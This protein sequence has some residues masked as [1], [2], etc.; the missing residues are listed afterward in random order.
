[1]LSIVPGYTRFARDQSAG[2]EVTPR[3]TAATRNLPTTAP[4]RSASTPA[5]ASQAAPA[6]GTSAGRG[7]TGRT[8]STGRAPAGAAAPRQD[9]GTGARPAAPLAPQAPSRQAPD[10]SGVS[11]VLRA[12]GFVASSEALQAVHTPEGYQV[13]A[14]AEGHILIRHVAIGEPVLGISP[15][16]RTEQML[17][18]Y[19]QALRAAGFHVT[20]HARGSLIVGPETARQPTPGRAPAG[21]A[22]GM[23]AP[24]SPA[25]VPDDAYRTPDHVAAGNARPRQPA[26]RPARE[27]TGE[28]E[29]GAPA[30]STRAEPQPPGPDGAPAPPPAGGGEQ[31]AHRSGETSQGITD[32]RAT[33]VGQ[34]PGRGDA[35]PQNTGGSPKQQHRSAGTGRPTGAAFGSGDLDRGSRLLAGTPGPDRIRPQ[36]PQEHDEQTSEHPAQG[37]AQ[38][39]AQ[40]T[41]KAPCPQCGKPHIRATGETYPCLSCE[42][43]A[44]LKAAGFTPGSREIKRVTEWNRPILDRSL[45]EPEMPQAPLKPETQTGQETNPPVMTRP[46]T[47]PARVKDLDHEREASG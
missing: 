43:Q 19:A 11:G 27:R 34:V 9:A 21:Q 18:I 25:P 40:G 10:A 30:T 33:T 38:P 29:T 3:R 8:R 24:V 4:T 12:A 26:R 22:A 7:H 23:Q 35:L 44:R 37:P 47:A 5:P 2:E 1:M 41:E 28:P 6:A 14:T 32:G 31:Q 36:R 45:R 39:V 15:P 46:A 42:T 17:A 16:A 13:Q 20:S